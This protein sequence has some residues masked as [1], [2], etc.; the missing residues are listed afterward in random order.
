MF[1]KF[2]SSQKL[3]IQ[4]KEMINVTK[5]LVILAI[6]AVGHWNRQERWRWMWG[7]GEEKRE[8]KFRK[9]YQ[10]VILL[11]KMSTFCYK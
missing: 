6:K 7:Q 9:I 1:F 2:E 11:Q 3:D 8:E 5:M 10:K 4:Y